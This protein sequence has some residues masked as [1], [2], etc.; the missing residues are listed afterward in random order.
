MAIMKLQILITALL[1]LS[2][3][4]AQAQLQGSRSVTFETATTNGISLTLSA[5]LFEPA[6][7][8]SVAVVLLHSSGGINNHVQG[9]YGREFS[10]SGHLV[11][12][13]DSFRPRGIIRT[14]D[15]Q[16]QV[17]SID[18]ALDGIYARKYL[19][20]TYPGVKKFV[21]MGF[22]KGGLAAMFLADKTFHPK[23]SERFD[24]HVAV[25]PACGFRAR[26]PKP[27]GSLLMLLG[28]KDEYTGL[29][30]CK[31]WAAEFEKAGGKADITVFADAY[32]SFDGA[33]EL[34]TPRYLPFAESFARCLV[35]V[36]DDGQWNYRGRL[37]P[38]QLATYA[39]L[40]KTCVKRG[41]SVGTNLKAKSDATEAVKQYLTR[42]EK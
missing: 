40:S 29:E 19:A 31:Q 25:Y 35:H 4:T 20:K 39:D 26:N 18:M 14:T 30:P 34:T 15:D 1:A 16:S 11:L 6:V 12:A 24:G 5:D 13:V 3:M 10:A 28:D 2:A 42:I 27:V 8:A 17:G 36:E 7:P 33:P 37:Y 23:E 32:H 9:H 41:A 22:S 21:V 38:A